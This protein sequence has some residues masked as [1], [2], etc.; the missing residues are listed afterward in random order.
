MTAEEARRNTD[1]KTLGTKRDAGR[2]LD[3]PE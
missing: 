3:A 1:P 2:H